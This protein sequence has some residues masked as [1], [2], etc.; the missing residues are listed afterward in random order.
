MAELLQGCSIT[1][2]SN[3]LIPSLVRAVPVRGDH[4][5]PLSMVTPDGMSSVRT[6]PLGEVN[7]NWNGNRCML[8]SRHDEVN[9]P[10]EDLLNGGILPCKLST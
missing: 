1:I 7:V 5:D 2:T 4:R 8:E 9:L 3:Y 10:Q 6:D